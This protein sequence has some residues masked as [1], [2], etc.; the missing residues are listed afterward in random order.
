MN[1]LLLEFNYDTWNES[2]T[3]ETN[4]KANEKNGNG[5]ERT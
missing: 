4:A 2:K 1:K 5:Y 3:N